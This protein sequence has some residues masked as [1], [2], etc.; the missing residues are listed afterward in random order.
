MAV[1]PIVQDAIVLRRAF[2]GALEAGASF[3]VAPKVSGRVETIAVDLA[4]PVRR[5]QVVAQLD[6]AEYEQ[7]VAQAQA[8]LAV[9]EANLEEARSLAAIARREVGMVTQRLLDRVDQIRIDPQ[10]RRHGARSLAREQGKRDDER[11]GAN[12]TANLTVH[13]KGGRGGAT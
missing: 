8:D 13:I 3:T 2:T 5:G 4:D 7:D 9:A 10:G 6:D 11:K 12:K 1:T